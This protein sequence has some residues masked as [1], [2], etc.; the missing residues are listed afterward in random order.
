MSRSEITYRLIF[1][2]Q[3]AVLQLL[4]QQGP[5]SEET[6]RPFFDSAKARSPKFYGEYSFENWIGFLIR[7]GA[8]LKEEGLYKI[9]VYGSEFLAWMVAAKAPKKIH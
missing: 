1:G 4:N 3:I 6:I 2:S 8:V 5:Q 7:E 9:T